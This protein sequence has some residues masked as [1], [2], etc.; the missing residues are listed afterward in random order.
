[1]SNVEKPDYDEVIQVS[2]YVPRQLIIKLMDVNGGDV[3]QKALQT[4]LETQIVRTKIKA[5]E[6]ANGGLS[7]DKQQGYLQEFVARELYAKQIYN[8]LRHYRDMG[9]F[10]KILMFEP[11]PT[12]TKVVDAWMLEM[13][14]IHHVRTSTFPYRDVTGSEA[15]LAEGNTPFPGTTTQVNTTFSIVGDLHHGLDLIPLAQEI[16]DEMNQVGRNPNLAFEPAA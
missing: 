4:V 9:G 14:R 2:P 3:T 5:V 10:I 12:H 13:G 8:M 15:P 1:M 7:D 16:F 11:D 6:S